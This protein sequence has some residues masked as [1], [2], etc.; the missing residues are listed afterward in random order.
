MPKLDGTGP[1]GLGPMT[2]RGLGLCQKGFGLRRGFF[3]RGLGRFF[4]WC[5]PRTKEE[6]KKALSEYKNALKEELE[7]V[8][9]EEEKLKTK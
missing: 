2:G 1:Q 8:E 6:Q 5:W 3:S 4:G 9:K 7:L